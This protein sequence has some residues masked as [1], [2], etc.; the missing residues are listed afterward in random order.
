MNPKISFFSPAVFL[1]VCTVLALPVADTAKADCTPP[2]S[3]M[4]GWWRAENSA[5]D[6]VATNS[7]SLVNGSFTNGVVGQAFAFYPN[8][9]AYG[10]YTGV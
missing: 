1:I 6:F 2:P 10:T 4:V 8:N 3:G 5:A 9:F 7:S